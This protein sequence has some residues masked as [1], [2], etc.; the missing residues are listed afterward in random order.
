[1]QSAVPCPLVYLLLGMAALAIDAIVNSI[2]ATPQRRRFIL[3]AFC[4][5]VV[6]SQFVEMYPEVMR[7]RSVS[8]KQAAQVRAANPALDAAVAGSREIEFIP[9]GDDP[10]GAPWPFLSYYAIKYKVPIYSYHWLARINGDEI[11][12]MRQLSAQ[13]AQECRWTT[14]RVYAVMR[15]FLPHIAQCNYQMDEV[16]AYPDWVVLKLKQP[17]RPLPPRRQPPRALSVLPSTG[18]GGDGISAWYMTIPTAPP[19]SRWLRP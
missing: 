14:D 19:T 15:S 9:A 7:F 10:A 5:V 18:S 4:L 16:A 12:R 13:A 17:G 3:M 8:W 2:P 1:M 6:L 11:G